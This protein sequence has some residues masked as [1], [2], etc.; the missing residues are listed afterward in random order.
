MTVLGASKQVR[1]M[2]CSVCVR[3]L[4]PL[5]MAIALLY[6]AVEGEQCVAVTW[7]ESMADEADETDS[8][9]PLFSHRP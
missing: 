8:F 5:L 4:A 6:R 9:F 1:R 3:S 2:L 7:T